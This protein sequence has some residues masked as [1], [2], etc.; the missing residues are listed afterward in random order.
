MREFTV[1]LCL[2]ELADVTPRNPHH[3]CLSA[4]DT[5]RLAKAEVK[6]MRPTKPQPYIKICRHTRNA[7]SRRNS[8][9]MW[10]WLLCISYVMAWKVTR[11]KIL[12][13]LHLQLGFDESKMKP[14]ASNKVA[15]TDSIAFTTSVIIFLRG[16]ITA[17]GCGPYKKHVKFI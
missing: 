6:W 16:I 9:C 7:E 17:Y 10:A 14:K 3:D 11:R 15:D 13:G 2:P 5:N 8:F 1:R 12:N 4:D